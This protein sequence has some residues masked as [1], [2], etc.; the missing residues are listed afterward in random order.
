MDG[1]PAYFL[2]DG[3]GGVGGYSKDQCH[4]LADGN[5]NKSLC[6]WCL[7]EMKTPENCIEQEFLCRDV[8]MPSQVLRETGA[9]T[10]VSAIT[11]FV[12]YWRVR[13]TQRH[14]ASVLLFRSF[15]EMCQAGLTFSTLPGVSCCNTKGAILGALMQFVLLSTDL[16][17]FF[18]MLDVVLGLNN[19]FR[20][21]Q[22]SA[23]FYIALTLAVAF[24]S[25]ITLVATREYG[26]DGNFGLCWVLNSGTSK[27]N[28]EKARCSRP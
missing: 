6:V 10:A 15:M 17:F 22:A 24:I 18:I 20:S 25:S 5:A 13:G 26:P 14:P 1:V 8:S 4:S 3:G 12:L 21:P 28:P 2:G 9:V 7:H 27:L 16:S 23:R 19:P 11:L